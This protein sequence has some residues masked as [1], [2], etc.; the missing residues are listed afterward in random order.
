MANE[1]GD[2]SSASIIGIR[3]N[4]YYKVRVD[5]SECL[6]SVGLS[7]VHNCSRPQAEL[8]AAGLRASLA[9]EGQLGSE[10]GLAGHD[11]SCRHLPVA[12]TPGTSKVHLL[13]GKVSPWEMDGWREAATAGK[14]PTE[15]G[16]SCMPG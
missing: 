5:L 6:D 7:A 9:K 10:L 14:I 1:G 16:S 8:K 15:L 13:E 12:P 11:I 3:P 2:I 4:N